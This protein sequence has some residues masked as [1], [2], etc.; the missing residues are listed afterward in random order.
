M[1]QIPINTNTHEGLSEY[2]PIGTSIDEVY[3][4]ISVNKSIIYN[5]RDKSCEKL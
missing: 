2:S 4:L 1:N 5:I 3:N